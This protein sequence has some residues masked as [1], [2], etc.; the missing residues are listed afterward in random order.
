MPSGRSTADSRSIRSIE[1]PR[2][3][4]PL[5]ARRISILTYWLGEVGQEV[6]LW[7]PEKANRKPLEPCLVPYSSR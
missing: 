1:S 3:H 6:R 5:T 4:I 2:G 7:V